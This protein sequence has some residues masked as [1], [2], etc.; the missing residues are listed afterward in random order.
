MNKTADACLGDLLRAAQAHVAAQTDGEAVEWEVC[1][2]DEGL[3]HPEIRTTIYAVSDD[4]EL[5]STLRGQYPR[6]ER[7]S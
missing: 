5:S 2:T 4:H 6:T 1:I 3:G 7:K